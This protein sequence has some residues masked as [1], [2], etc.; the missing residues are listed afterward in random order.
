MLVTLK[1]RMKITAGE[2]NRL[3]VPAFPYGPRSISLAWGKQA[4]NQDPVT[5]RETEGVGSKL[6]LD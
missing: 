2:S 3:M 5:A 4:D 1:L 6:W